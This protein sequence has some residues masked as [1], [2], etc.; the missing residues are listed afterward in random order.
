M[1]GSAT[2]V[3]RL[4]TRVLPL[5]LC[6]TLTIVAETPDRG[7]SWPGFRGIG[8]DAIVSDAGIIA[9]GATYGFRIRWKTPLGSGYSGVSVAEGMAVTMYSDDT[10][11]YMIA[12]DPMTGEERW[13][14]RIDETHHGRYGS[15]DGPISTPLISDGRVIGLGPRGQLFSLD[16]NT[17]QP[18]WSHHLVETFGVKSPMVY[19]FTTSPIRVGDVLVVETSNPDGSAVTG[20]DIE[21]GNVLWKAGND[22]VAFQSPIPIE[23]NGKA[24]TLIATTT[25]LYGLNPADGNILWEFRH[26]S[27]P[28]FT[29][30]NLNPVAIGNNRIYVKR[31][32]GKL[33]AI[34]VSE[35]EGAYAVKEVWETR[36]LQR[37]YVV[38]VVHEGYIYGLNGRF[39]SCFDAATGKVV[40]KSR[41]PG[42]GFP[43][44]IDGHLV[45]ITKKGT[46]HLA[47]A[48]PEGYADMAS[49]KV[50]DDLVWTPPS[51]AN[52]Q[53]Y[54][55]SFGEIACVEIVPDAVTLSEDGTPPGVLPESDFAAFVAKVES[56]GAGERAA[57]IDSWMTA[58]KRFPVIE[59]DR[60]VH[61]IY[62]GEADDVAIGSDLIG[63][64]MD[65][66][67]HRIEGTDLYYY[68]IDVEPDARVRYEFLINT[69]EWAGD[70]LN[71]ETI[72]MWGRPRTVLTMPSFAEP[73]YL[74]EPTGER[75]RVDS[76]SFVGPNTGDTL[77]LDVYL[78]PGY[79]ADSET[80]YPVAY[81]I[82]GRFVQQEGR[83]NAALDNLI[84]SDLPPM[85]MVYVYPNFGGWFIEYVGDFRDPHADMLITDIIPH[86]D[87]TYRTQAGPEGRAA[88]GV[89]DGAYM[90]LYAATRAPGTFGGV[91]M[92]SASWGDYEEENIR[93]QMKTSAELP[94]RVYHDWGRYDYVSPMEG[95]NI[96]V[97]NRRLRTWLTD[98]GYAVDGGEVNQAGGWPFWRNRSGAALKTLFPIER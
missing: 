24:Q 20:F 55:R 3:C 40:W 38:P 27:M 1:S 78:P 52:G 83:M 4:I 41:Q 28:N 8:S 85:I 75:G 47:K 15:A 64:R 53:V 18:V 31:L 43:I 61:F 62:R 92:M 32:G 44:L 36:D 19:G 81:M 89:D 37:S 51:F 48:S 22:S 16:L 56:A 63:A 11:D 50:F 26:D 68:S 84:G 76:V 10:H 21:T 7:Q 94:M 35:A 59:G 58:Q 87:A 39:F 71:S 45:T 13:R 2:T 79:D 74:A 70:T 72:T 82:D 5:A 88:F 33:K 14:Y 9:D 97:L 66:P 12:L 6:L 95:T 96:P 17:G 93:D 86:V 65:H 29:G 49:I 91:A 98:H 54:L 73:A 42:D 57:M 34:E 25:M 30:M 23:I 46:L 90:A 60:T 80:R 69:T 67:M 77:R